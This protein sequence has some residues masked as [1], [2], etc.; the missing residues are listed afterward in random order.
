MRTGRVLIAAVLFLGVGVWV[1]FAYCHG[2]AGL[3]FSSDLT[4]NKVSLDLTT[5]G[6]PM[7][8]GLPLV[9]IGMLLMLISFISAIVIQ[10]RKP[11][12]VSRED[13]APRREVPFE[14]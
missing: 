10:F 6:T 11:P 4:G 5:V 14:E 2:S 12:E 13:E 3:N 1:L 8:V 9:G 7:L